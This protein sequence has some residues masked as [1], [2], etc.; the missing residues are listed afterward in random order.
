MFHIVI[1]EG[2]YCRYY[3]ERALNSWRSILGERVLSLKNHEDL[4]KLIVETLQ[5]FNGRDSL[6]RNN[7]YKE[8]R[9]Y[10]EDYTC[11]D[12]KIQRKRKIGFLRF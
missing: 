9:N 12:F 5:R 1:E 11:D 6:D 4:A 10:Y 3:P 8:T 7:N 2:S